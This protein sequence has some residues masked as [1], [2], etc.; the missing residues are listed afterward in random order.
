MESK[1]PRDAPEQVARVFGTGNTVHQQFFRI[2]GAGPDRHTRH[3]VGSTPSSLPPVEHGRGLDERTHRRLRLIATT[4]LSWISAIQNPDGG[5]PTDDRDTPSCT[6]TTAGL[7]W[8]VSCY[9]V[10]KDARWS[11]RAATWLLDQLSEDGGLPTVQKGD[12]TTTDATAQALLAAVNYVDQDA[13]G[14]LRRL[15]RWLVLSQERDGPWSWLK[16][17][18]DS[19]VASTAFAVLAL[20]AYLRNCPDE[21]GDAAQAIAD[22]L[23]WLRAVQNADG[24]W[25]DVAGTPSRASSTGLAIFS[26]SGW[27]GTEDSRMAGGDYLADT[28]ADGWPNGLERPSSHTIVRLGVPYAILGLTSTPSA[29]HFDQ[30]VSAIPALLRMYVDGS[31]VLAGTNTRSWPTRDGLLALGSLLRGGSSDTADREA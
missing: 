20:Q 23:G 1:D 16:W 12:P 24:G 3:V 9:G 11:R 30:G 14:H 5:L 25:G 29:S 17:A 18:G 19:R 10:D 4:C 15:A 26:L 27:G 28:Y 8:A 21:A 2:D 22:A 7:L 13:D 6:W 31:F